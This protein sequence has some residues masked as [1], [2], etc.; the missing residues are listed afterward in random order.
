MTRKKKLNRS[1]L[2]GAAL[3]LCLLATPAQADWNSGEPY[4]WVQYP[5]LSQL[6]IDVHD[7]EPFILADDFLCDR[8]GP[9]T[10]IHL[11]GSWLNDHVPNG[12]CPRCVTFILSIHA[13]IP[14]S[15]NPDGYSI[16]GELLWWR[17]FQPSDFAVRIWAENLQEGWLRPPDVYL[18]PADTICWQYNFL[19][20]TA[21]AFVQQGTPE[22]PVVYWLDVQ[23]IPEDPVAL[24]GWKTS[25]YHWNDNAVWGFGGEPYGGPWSE[26]RYPPGHEQQGQSIDLS[27][28]MVGEEQQ[29]FDFGDAPDAVGA[30]F[31]RT[32][33]ANN[34]ARHAIDPALY[35]GASPP[36]GEPDGQPHPAALG[37][38]NNGIDDEDGVTFVTPMI[39]GQPA[40][41]DVVSSA[42]ARLDAWIDW[43]Q[44]NSFAGDHLFGGISFVVFPGNNPISFTVPA[45]ALIGPT[46][47]RFRLSTGGGLQPFGAA[48]NGEVEDYQIY[49][50]QE[51]TGSI[52]DRVWDD[53]DGDGIQDAGE[54]G[55]P[56]V[57]VRLFDCGGTLIASTAT[58]PAGNYW[59][60]GLPPGDYYLH[61]S[62]L[63]GFVY[64]PQD[65]GADDTIDSDANQATGN[66]VC[67][68][69]SSGEVD[70]TWDCGM[71]GEPPLDLDYGDAPDPGY[72]TLFASDGA[73]HMIAAGA[74]IFL[75]AGVD[76]EPDGQPDATATG[77]DLDGN[78]DEDGIVFLTPLNPGGTAEVLVTAGAAGRLNAWV[79]FDGDGDWSDPGEQIFSDQFITAGNSV[80]AFSVP[81]TGLPALTTFAR[82]RFNSAGGLGF[83]GQAS[84]GEVEDYEVEVE[85]DLTDAP[86]DALPNRY[87]LRQNIPNPFNPKTLIRFELP[88]AGEVTIEV[89]D[90]DGRTLRVLLS[91]SLPAGYH[92][93]S[94]DGRDTSGRGLPTGVYL[95]RLRANGYSETRKMLLL[96]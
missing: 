88:R 80:L 37:D 90:V 19:I 63:V 81:A 49:V 13:D 33:L 61:F 89:F 76:A 5:D 87:G 27:F 75:G 26:L 32:L 53:L 4:K 96:Q 24:Y 23:A 25:Q 8:P 82:F 16:P 84:D 70:H 95:Y 67:T 94:W 72:P 15:Q 21:E 62:L 3:A 34:G 41:I 7:S 57:P 65:Q 31:Y 28:V 79:D 36:D 39:P 55:L 30:P 29:Q 52:G 50:E 1:L 74:P 48:S 51:Q 58:D 18:F 77:D 10:G 12:D 69:I 22:N 92:E 78:D 91:G 6:G 14:A 2:A 45:V 42:L 64:S 43:G 47:A 68:T 20:P 86:A 38:D 46:Y 71:H 40:S 11:W 83:T 54:P 9:I 85:L 59:F 73:R 60:V 56:N 35:M 44:D 93:V 17:V 66:T